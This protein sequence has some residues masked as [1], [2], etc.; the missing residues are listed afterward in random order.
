MKGG[1]MKASGEPRAACRSCRHFHN[2]PAYL[3]AEIPGLSALSS[4][5]ASVRADDGICTLH[6]R[7]QNAR[8]WCPSFHSI[9]QR[10]V[11]SALT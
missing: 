7:L 8:S 2:D 11:S 10:R 4:A 6:G 3:E 9:E 1:I 5:Y